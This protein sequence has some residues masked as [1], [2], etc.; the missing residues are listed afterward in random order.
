MAF[1]KINFRRPLIRMLKIFRTAL[2]YWD[3]KEKNWILLQIT[4]FLS[5]LRKRKR[6]V[7][8]NISVIISTGPAFQKWRQENRQREIKKKRMR[9]WLAMHGWFLYIGLKQREIVTTFVSSSQ[10]ARL[11]SAIFGKPWSFGTF[12]LVLS[13]V[14][15]SNQKYRK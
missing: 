5:D 3:Y 6:E 14:E 8:N 4:W 1:W 9:W 13:V 12:G 7:F 2:H 11:F 15:A 10:N